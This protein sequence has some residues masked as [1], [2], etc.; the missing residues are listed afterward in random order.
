MVIALKNSMFLWLSC[1]MLVQ[2]GSCLVEPEQN[3]RYRRWKA[4][5][6]QRI[7]WL[8]EAGESCYNLKGEKGQA[9]P[10]GVSG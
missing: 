10:L 7:S 5:K 9:W 6:K 4:S 2:E 8:G 3:I 1:G